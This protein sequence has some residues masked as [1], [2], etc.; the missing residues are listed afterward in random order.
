MQIYWPT[1]FSQAREAFIESGQIEAGVPIRTVC[2]R[3][4]AKCPR[5]LVCEE[6]ELIVCFSC[7]SPP[8]GESLCLTCAAVRAREAA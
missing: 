3:C 6:C 1:I 7:S 5:H 2:H 8:G 4:G